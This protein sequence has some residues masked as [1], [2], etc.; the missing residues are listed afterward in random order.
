MAIEVGV[1]GVRVK[2]MIRLSGSGCDHGDVDYGGPFT[3]TPRKVQ[4]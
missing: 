4:F 1:R 3:D 2:V